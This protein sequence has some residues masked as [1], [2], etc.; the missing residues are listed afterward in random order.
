MTAESPLID[1]KQ[2]AAAASI[3]TDIIDRIPKGRDFTSVITT[4][5][6]TNDEARAGG[7]Q[8]DG[9]SGSENRFI[10]DGMDTTNLR[11]G[12]STRRT[13]TTVLTDFLQEV[14][15]KSSR[16]QRRVRRLD[17]RRHQRDHQVRQQPVPRQRRH[18]LPQRRAAERR[19]ARA[20]G[21][22]R[23]PT[24]GDTCTGT[25][26]FVATPDTAFDNWNPIGDLGG[27][28][29]HDKAWFYFGVQLQPH[30]QRADDHVPQLAGAVRRRKTM[31][32][33][34]DARV[35]QLQRDDAADDEPAASRQR[36]E[37]RAAN[38][39]SIAGSLQ[40]DGS[41]FADGTSTN[42][43]NTATWDADPEKFKDRWER[44]GATAATI[45]MSAD[46]DWVLT[47]KFFVNVQAGYLRLRQRRRRRSSPGRSCIHTLQPV[48][49]VHRR[50]GS[51]SC[52]FPEIPANLQQ[53]SGYADNKSTSRTVTTSTAAP[54]ST[55]TRPASSRWTGEHQFKVGVQFE[56]LEQRPSTPAP[57]SRRSRSTGTAHCTTL[58]G[59]TV[60]GTYGYYTVSRGLHRRASHSNNWSFWLQDAGRSAQLTVNAGVR[61]ENENVPSYQAEN[62]GIEF[63]FGDKIAPRVGFAYD[64]KGDSRWK[65]YGS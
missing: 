1:V 2:N 63:G 44:T 39:G 55:P 8:I 11:T 23:S 20:G 52:P 41:L 50:A 34:S 49:H 54:T 45:C 16:L 22:I 5:P 7:L 13:A 47:P 30:R 25:P 31:T 24:A 61:T 56:R 28:I 46:L 33:W 64:I 57:S 27:P 65:A 59:R 26:E 60:R 14:Q 36:R 9:S 38:R 48:E 6:G 10:V 4:A 3:P 58:D 15:V 37:T 12:T 42:G 18:L 43:F 17:R 53:I 32:S 19:R 51:A 62:P 29:L 40:P 21:S 35:L